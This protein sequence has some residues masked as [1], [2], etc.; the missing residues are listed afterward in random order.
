MVKII[1]RLISILTLI[2]SI[3]IP[4]VIFAQSVDDLTIMTENYPPFNFIKNDKLQGIAVDLLIKMLEK[5]NSKKTLSDLESMAWARAYQAVRMKA[6]TCLFSMVRSKKREHLFKWAG[7]IAPLT[8]AIIALKSKNI[9]IKSIDD[10]SK[11]QIGV[12]RDDIGEQLLIEKGVKKSYLDRIHSQKLNIK[13]LR[14]GRIDICAYPEYSTL[15]QIKELGFDPDEFETVYVLSKDLLYYA[16]HKD[17]PDSLI[18]Q[19]QNALDELKKDGTYQEI[20]NK[21][22]K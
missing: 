22:L 13:K 6:K 12:V 10:L 17:T 7:P 8:I 21:Y 3:S 20:L 19:F 9:K 16:F 4:S 11:F 1:I 5:L 15:W 18:Q 2:I 14:L